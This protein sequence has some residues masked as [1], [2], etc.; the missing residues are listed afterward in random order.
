MKNFRFNLVAALVFFAVPIVMHAQS[1]CS[2]SPEA[3]TAVLMLIGS[4]GIYGSSVAISMLRRV[5]IGV[6]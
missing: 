6:L 5:K 1:G 2:D 4:A 3:P